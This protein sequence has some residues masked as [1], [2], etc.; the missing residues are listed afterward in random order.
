MKQQTSRRVDEQNQKI[1][2]KNVFF[3]FLNSSTGLLVYSSTLLLLTACGFAPLYGTHGNAE[4]VAP[5]LA[6]VHVGV[7]PDAIG[8]ELRNKI[9][10]LMP[11]PND[12]PRYQLKIA[13]AEGGLGVAIA[14][15]TTVTR[16][17][18]RDNLHA[19]LFDTKTQ[20]TVWEA[21]TAATASYSV[22]N[23]QFSNLVAAQ[24][25]QRRNLDELSERVVNQLSLYFNLPEADRVSIEKTLPQHPAANTGAPASTTP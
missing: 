1:F 15:D 21:D 23:S 19:E 4:T 24:D 22:L 25:A 14:R 3:K 13:L 11:P 2:H 17:Q 20:K 10:D 8:Q 12:A 6:D 9:L 16:Q 5:Q 18:L 7:I